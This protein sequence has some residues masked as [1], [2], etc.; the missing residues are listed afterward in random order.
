MCACSPGHEHL[1][2]LYLVR[3][4][5][6][7]DVNRDTPPDLPLTEGVKEEKNRRDGIDATTRRGIAKQVHKQK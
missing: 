7:K 6:G 5:K 2:V 4:Q 1:I 3:G